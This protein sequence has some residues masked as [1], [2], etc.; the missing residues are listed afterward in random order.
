MA[1]VYK[2]VGGRKIEKVIAVH[3]TVQDR[4]DTEILQAATRAEA[5]LAR[6]RKTG[7]AKIEVDEGRVDRYLVLVDE[8]G[9]G[10]AMSIELGHRS[11]TPGGDEV[12]YVEGLHILGDAM[13][14]PRRGR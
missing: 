14:L 3:A 6:H 10:A 8:A 4:L 12:G 13:G 1:Q 5:G 7:Q 9:A 11:V 2:R